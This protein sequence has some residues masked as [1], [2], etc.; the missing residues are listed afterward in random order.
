MKTRCAKHCFRKKV[1]TMFSFK[2]LQ[3]ASSLEKLQVVGRRKYNQGKEVSV[4][5]VGKKEKNVGLFQRSL[6]RI[7]KS[8]RH[9]QTT[10][11]SVNYN[12]GMMSIIM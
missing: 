10:A 12:A 11:C 4:N 9:K 5:R 6:D 2:A 7:Q 3:E 8:I 1:I